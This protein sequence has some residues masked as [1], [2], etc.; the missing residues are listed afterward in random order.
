MGEQVGD[1]GVGRRPVFVR[2]ASNAFLLGV[3]IG[4]VAFL[5]LV[6]F[7]PSRIPDLELALGIVGIAAPVVLF[8]W[9]SFALDRGRPG[10]PEAAVIV[11][12]AVVWLGVLQLVLA[13][14][15]GQ[16]MIPLDALV[17]AWA[18]TAWDRPAIQLRRVPPAVAILL[19][20][21]VAARIGEPVIGTA[22]A[23]GLADAS[24]LQLAITTDCDAAAADLDAPLVVHVTWGWDRRE[25]IAPAQDAIELTWTA[26]DAGRGVYPSAWVL[27][28][29]LGD[30]APG[31]AMRVLDEETATTPSARFGFDP[32]QHPAGQLDLPL[33][34]DAG[35]RPV[36]V[37]LAVRYAHGDAWTRAEVTT[38][39][40]PAP[41]SP[42]ATAP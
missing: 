6:G 39:E 7:G 8:G 30:E 12:W 31:V 15:R 28:D 1:P 27:P 4:I 16:L 34:V 33:E 29:W 17:A 40:L 26:D 32:A 11:L 13:L 18:L 2:R 38:C 25:L 3:L 42:A 20:V 24:E 9:L 37:S 23:F 14:V 21:L 5:L 19:V 10:A 35:A 22:R 41:P 36:V